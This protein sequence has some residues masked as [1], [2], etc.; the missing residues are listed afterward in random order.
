MPPST[1][2]PLWPKI[3]SH[4]SKY[5]L[6]IRKSPM[7]RFGVFATKPIAPNRKVIEYSGERRTWA[8]DTRLA[9]NSERRGEARNVYR[10]Y[11]QGRTVIDA[12]IGGSGAEF[13]NHCCAPNLR[14]RVLRGRIFLFSLRQ[15]RPG[16]ELS[17]DYQL[18]SRKKVKCRCN[19]PNCR[20]TLN[21]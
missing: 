12:T 8:Q 6:R 2:K 7:H 19:S 5:R 21:P 18:A 10:A 9:R 16:E 20:G 15:I 17:W 1:H 13:I 14:P 4:F 11:I 3:P